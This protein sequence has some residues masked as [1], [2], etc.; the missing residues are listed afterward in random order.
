MRAFL[1]AVTGL[2][3]WLKWLGGKGG[4][5]AGVSGGK[6]KLQVKRVSKHKEMFLYKKNYQNVDGFKIKNIKK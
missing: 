2:G 1:P 4:G 3:L 5:G 6:K